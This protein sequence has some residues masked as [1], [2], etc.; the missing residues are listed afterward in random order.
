MSWLEEELKSTLKRRN[1]PDGFADRVLARVEAQSARPRY[2]WRWMTAM[3]A[4]ILLLL[5][6][7]EYREEQ[8]RKEAER[9]QAEVR[10]AFEITQEKFEFVRAQLSRIAAKGE[11]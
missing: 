5:G 9:V 8:R 11:I 3:A 6:G 7:Y 1:P 4:S 10:L 2:E